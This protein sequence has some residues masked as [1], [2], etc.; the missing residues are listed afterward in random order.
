MRVLLKMTQLSLSSGQLH[1]MPREKA[2][3]ILV[4]DD[5]DVVRN[6]TIRVLGRL[7]Y[8]AIAVGNGREALEYCRNNSVSLVITDVSMP[9]KNGIELIEDLQREF[10]KVPVIGMSGHPHQLQLARQAG[11]VEGISKPFELNELIAALHK[12]LA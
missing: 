9:V 7:S 12:A 4:V 6:A 8:S 3:T 1:T 2:G 10:P 5:D 11:A